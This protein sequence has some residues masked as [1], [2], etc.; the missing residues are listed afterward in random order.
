MPARYRID[1]P[2]TCQKADVFA[3]A[4]LQEN[5]LDEDGTITGDNLRGLSIL[6]HAFAHHGYIARY[7]SIG[8]D[9]YPVKDGLIKAA[10]AEWESYISAPESTATTESTQT[11]EQ[12]MAELDQMIGLS[13]MKDTVKDVMALS[14]IDKQ[15]QKAGLSSSPVTRHMVFTGNPG[16]GKTSVARI[17]GHIYKAAGLLQKGHFVE[18]SGR[19]LVAPYIGQTHGQVKAIIDQALDGILFIDEAYSLS[20]SN[21]DKDFGQEAIASLIK[22]MEDYRERLIVIVAGYKHEMQRFI[23]ANPGLQSRFKT[24]I[25]FPDYAQ[26]ELIQIIEHLFASHDYLLSHDASM[27][28]KALIETIYE[29]KDET[30]G[31]GRDMRNLYETIITA[32]A[33]RLITQNKTGIQALKR[34]IARDI[35]D[36]RA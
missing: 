11:I 5:K 21:A 29:T 30:F 19:D 7:F 9:S 15:R 28:L 16:T 24:T 1:P 14:L 23:S 4:V 34:I 17:I 20:P 22:Y 13:A 10:Q 33:R 35:R 3:K 18:L 36:E 8:E 6:Y 26:S 2:L 32:Q 25:D 27:K 12:S 31:N